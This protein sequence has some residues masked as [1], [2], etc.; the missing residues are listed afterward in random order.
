[1]Q[2]GGFKERSFLLEVGTKPIGIWELGPNL[3]EF[4]RSHRWEV[5]NW[6]SGQVTKA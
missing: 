3:L 1:M 5:R 4:E 2:F 6:S